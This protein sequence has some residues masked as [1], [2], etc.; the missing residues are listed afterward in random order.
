VR[1][2][3]E[4]GQ[5]WIRAAHQTLYLNESHHKRCETA[6]LDCLL[7]FDAQ[8]ALEKGLL[9]RRQAY[10]VLCGL[11]SPDAPEI[12]SL[13]SETEPTPS[14]VSATKRSKQERLARGQQVNKS[15]QRK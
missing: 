2:L 12:Y 15:R 4:L 5:D 3:L 9:K 14:V 13:R 6:C 11:L 8:E 7:T 10:E 1:G